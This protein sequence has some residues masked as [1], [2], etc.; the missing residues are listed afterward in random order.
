MKQ[1]LEKR[2]EIGITDEALKIMIVLHRKQNLNHFRPANFFCI[3]T[4]LRLQNV[5]FTNGS[6][7]N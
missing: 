7:V 5:M 1:I 2:H 3:F 6:N 4:F